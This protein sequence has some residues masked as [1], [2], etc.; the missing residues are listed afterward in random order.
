MKRCM[1]HIDIIDGM[2]DWNSKQP[3]GPQIGLGDIC[4]RPYRTNIY[5]HDDEDLG[6]AIDTIY[7]RKCRVLAISDWGDNASYFEPEAEDIEKY[8]YD[9]RH[10]GFH[11][12]NVFY[13]FVCSVVIQ[14][15]DK[16]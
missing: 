1:A 2:D 7:D 8:G 12:P 5:F 15:V 3:G 13:P 11:D 6:G 16:S 10:D 9:P 4:D 14:W